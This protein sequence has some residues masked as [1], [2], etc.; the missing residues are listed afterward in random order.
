MFFEGATVAATDATGI[1][2]P[3]GATQTLTINTGVTGASFA[4][5]LASKKSH[6]RLMRYI[7]A[8]WGAAL[9]REDVY[10]ASEADTIFES[11]WNFR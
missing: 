6:A 2:A 7:F 5:A 4:S 1:P 11:V 8:N 9:L 10:F 3:S